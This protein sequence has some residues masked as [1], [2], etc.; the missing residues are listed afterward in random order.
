MSTCAPIPSPQQQAP[1]VTYISHYGALA[2]DAKKGIIGKQIDAATKREA[3]RGALAECKQSG[4]D[5]CEVYVDFVNSCVAM[6]TGNGGFGVDARSRLED[7]QASAMTKCK[8]T[9]DGCHIYY[10]ACN[11]PSGAAEY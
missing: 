5:K 2:V 7:A 11:V 1:T 8:T 9:G 4:G 6:A 3:V 10:D